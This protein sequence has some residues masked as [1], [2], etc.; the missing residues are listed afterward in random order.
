MAASA[1]QASGA[2]AVLAAEQSRVRREVRTTF[3]LDEAD[4]KGLAGR[5]GGPNARHVA[6]RLF[7]EIESVWTDMA[8]SDSLEVVEIEQFSD[9]YFK[10]LERLP[11]LEAY[12]RELG[13]VL[14]AGVDVSI[15]IGGGGED[16]LSPLRIS[17]LVRGFRGS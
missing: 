10:V 14:V 3:D 1:R 15:K 2:S 11:E 16:I 4:K 17:R 5:A 8:H 9:A 6:G 12:L 7:I 13:E